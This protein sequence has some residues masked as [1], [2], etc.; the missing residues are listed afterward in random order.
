MREELSGDQGSGNQAIRRSS[1]QAIRQ[2]GDQELG[3]G[4][5]GHN[6]AITGLE[7]L[8]KIWN[9]WRRV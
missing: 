7:F 1:N 5:V 6:K 3:I 9:E 8:E 4:G 2:S